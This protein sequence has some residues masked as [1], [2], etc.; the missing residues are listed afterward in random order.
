ML[1][2]IE[3][4]KS[5]PLNKG[6]SILELAVA[7]AVVGLIMVMVSGGMKFMESAKLKGVYAEIT[8]IKAAKNEF[9]SRYEFWPGD[10]PYADKI[11]GAKCDATATNCNGDGNGLVWK[12]NGSTTNAAGFSEPLL[13][14]RHL[15]L[16]GL[17]EGDYIGKTVGTVSGQACSNHWSCCVNDPSSLGCPPSEYNNGLWVNFSY[18]AGTEGICDTDGG[19]SYMPDNIHIFRL[20]K[21]YA[22]GAP[23]T[24]IMKPYHNYI[25]DAKYDDGSPTTGVIQARSGTDTL[26]SGKGPCMLNASDQTIANGAAYGLANI[27]Y[28]ETESDEVCTP[29]FL[30]TKNLTCPLP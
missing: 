17:I 29:Y 19:T 25:L 23:K 2:E 26:V 18:P 6:F 20:A 10:F 14:W 24:G 28:N 13:F 3:L 1:Q 5:H 9:I 7:V 12:I 11:W 27:R 21:F 22:A 8:K 4:K 15:S 30:S 16:E